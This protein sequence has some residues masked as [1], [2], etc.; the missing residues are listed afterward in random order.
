MAAMQ[1]NRRVSGFT[2][3]EAVVVMFITSVV[4]A[5]LLPGMGRAR[6]NARTAQGLANLQQ[7]GQGV[8]IMAIDMNNTLPYGYWDGTPYT[9]NNV[10]DQETDWMLGLNDY[11]AGGG[12]TYTALANS[13]RQNVVLPIFRDPSATHPDNGLHHYIGHPLLLPDRDVV[14]DT[15]NLR[16]RAVVRYRLTRLRRPDEVVLAMDGIQ[17][18]NTNVNVVNN[19]LV[20][21]TSRAAAD[22]MDNGALDNQTGSFLNSAFYDAGDADLN[23]LIAPGVNQ[24]GIPGGGVSPANNFD[25]RWRQHNDTAANFVFPDGHSETLG[26][27]EVRKRNIRV[28]R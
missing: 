15:T 13:S 14:E 8:Y 22:D 11:L 27:N 5:L 12:D 17:V 16:V 20:Q 21:Y 10:N 4:M 7:L 23:N 2:I 3:T 6:D 24:D 26:M 9:S 19:P 1:C 18:Y 25:V 28:D